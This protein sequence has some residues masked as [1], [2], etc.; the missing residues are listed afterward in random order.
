MFVVS[1]ESLAL[2]CNLLNCYKRERQREIKRRREKIKREKERE[3]QREGERGSKL[4]MIINV[5]FKSGVRILISFILPS[6]DSQSPVFH[7]MDRSAFSIQKE[8]GCGQQ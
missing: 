4:K 7:E 6:E 3:R 1:L 2:P 5:S 8:L